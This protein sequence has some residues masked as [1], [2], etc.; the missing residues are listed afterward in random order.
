MGYVRSSEVTYN[1]SPNSVVLVS[2]DG[3]FVT[4][5]NTGKGKVLL[6]NQHPKMPRP[7][8]IRSVVDMSGHAA[9]YLN[10]TTPTER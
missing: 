7:S 8:A 6:D 9:R 3:R 1:D 10:L 5:S 2:P 4:E